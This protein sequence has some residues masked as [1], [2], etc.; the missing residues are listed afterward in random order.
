MSFEQIGILNVGEMGYHWARLLR[1]HGA[2]VLT[3]ARDRSDVTRQRCENAQVEQLESLEA[4]VGR[5]DVIVSIV[6]PS[7][8]LDVARRVGEAALKV[9][10]EGLVF[11]DA[12]AISPMTAGAIEA[13]LKPAGVGFVDGCII[14]SAQRLEKASVYVS[15]PGAERLQDLGAFGLSIRVLG[16]KVAQASAFK[17]VYAG[18]TK[19]LAGLLTELLM[20]AK[21]FDLLDEILDRYEE[22]FPGLTQ[23]VG[24]GITSL[25]LHAG[26]RSEEMAELAETFRHFG[27]NP[28]VT[29]S[30][31]GILKSIAA[32]ELGQ[33]SG[34]GERTGSLVETIDL[35]AAKGL[36][37]D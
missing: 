33:P 2:T 23:K 35:F 36:L 7:A 3:Y 13:Q 11:V 15:G 4:L 16:E 32:L 34:K 28:I 24:G 25:P 17:V 19:G 27:L 37:S 30:I 18:L 31:E 8:A 6:I 20:G 14:G 21:R 5:A 1:S 9:G 22:S 10:R 29:P 26:R 12:N